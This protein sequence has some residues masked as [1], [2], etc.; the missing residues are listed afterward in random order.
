MLHAFV[1]HKGYG[2]NLLLGGMSYSFNITRQSDHDIGR[3]GV[4]F[5]MFKFTNNLQLHPPPWGSPKTHIQALQQ[6]PIASQWDSLKIPLSGSPKISNYTLPLRLANTPSRSQIPS[7]CT[8][9]LTFL[10]YILGVE[11]MDA[12]CVYVVD[13]N[14]VCVDV[15]GVHALYDSDATL[16]LPFPRWRHTPHFARWWSWHLLAGKTVQNNRRGAQRVLINIQHH[17]R[18]RLSRTDQCAQVRFSSAH[19]R[20]I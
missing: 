12:V 9:N 1:L 6:P 14:V 15:E 5:N 7:N 16:H 10:P 13:G 19:R 20:E 17:V 3:Q 18:T 11:V 8:Q 4:L 2:T